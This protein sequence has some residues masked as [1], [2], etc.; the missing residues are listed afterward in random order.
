MSSVSIFLLIAYFLPSI[1][2]VRGHL[3]A[4]A[5]VVL[6][7]LLGWTLLGW[8]IAMVWSMTGNTGDNV[9]RYYGRPDAPKPDGIGKFVDAS[10]WR[11]KRV[12]RAAR[13]AVQDELDL[14]PD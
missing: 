5:I 4:G 7:L 10:Y 2:S 11:N 12:A 6:N 8:I 1:A 9:L 3:S 13:E 14:P